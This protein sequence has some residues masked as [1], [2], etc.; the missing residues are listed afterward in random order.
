MNEMDA[1]SD[2][3]GQQHDSAAAPY[4]CMR[5]RYFGDYELLR[6]LG[7]GGMGIV[8]EAR[9]NSLDRVIALK[10]IPAGRFAGEIERRRFG[11]E[12][13]AVA[14]LDHPH[15]VPVYE[16]GEH[17]GHNY[18]SM[19][20]IEGTSLAANLSGVS[21]SA[22]RGGTAGGHHGAGGAPRPRARR[23]ASRP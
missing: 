20:R 13:E 5:V 2:Q 9:Q 21:R 15:I 6:I 18:F 8:Y 17:E 12:A 1:T 10:M 3:S 19:K 11:N 4:S 22:A 14:R 7:E 16:V 23:A